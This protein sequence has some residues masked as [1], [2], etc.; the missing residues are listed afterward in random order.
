MHLA[1]WMSSSLGRGRPTAFP[2]TLV[3]RD[4]FCPVS[5]PGLA[6]PDTL[7]FHGEKGPLSGLAPRPG[8]RRLASPEDCGGAGHLGS[9]LS[10]HRLQFSTA[11]LT[12]A[13]ADRTA[14]RAPPAGLGRTLGTS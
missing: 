3:P 11:I 14:R 9:R 1:F 8:R 12:G 4:C 5:S 2:V 10:N 7:P 6:R 13:S